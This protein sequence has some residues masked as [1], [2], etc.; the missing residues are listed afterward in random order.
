[1]SAHMYWV[2]HRLGQGI[3][4]VVGQHTS[5]ADTLISFAFSS[6]SCFIKRTICSI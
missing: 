3:V 4:R 6:A 5:S 1:M 2:V